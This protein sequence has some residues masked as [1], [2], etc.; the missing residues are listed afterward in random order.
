MSD[1][2]DWGLVVAIHP[3]YKGFGWVVFEGPLAPVDWGIA[4]SKGNRSANSMRRLQEILNQYQP[5]VLVLEEFTGDRTRRGARMQDL[6]QSMRAL[7]TNRD[8]EVAIY[9]R[10]LVSE[11]VADDPKSKRHRLAEAVCELLPILRFRLPPKR[12]AWQ[13]EDS[14]HC[15]FTAAALAIA[16]FEISRPH[17]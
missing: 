2:Q 11:L 5:S 13:T 12:T 7:A 16:H 4:S 9:P 17:Q 15:L 10:K 14:R 6:A 8:I 1:R 3:T